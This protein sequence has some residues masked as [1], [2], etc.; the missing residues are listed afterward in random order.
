MLIIKI[1]PTETTWSLV[2]ETAKTCI[3]QNHSKPIPT[4]T[5]RSESRILYIVSLSLNGSILTPGEQ[6]KASQNDHSLTILRDCMRANPRADHRLLNETRFFKSLPPKS[7]RYALPA[8]LA[9]RFVRTGRDAL[10]HHWA[11]VKAKSIIPGITSLISI[12]LNS[13]PNAVAI[14]NGQPVDLFAGFSLLDGLPG[15]HSCG[16]IDPSLCLTLSEKGEPPETIEQLLTTQSGLSSLSPEL[17]NFSQVFEQPECLASKFLAH[18]LKKTMGGM[19]SALNALEAI[20]FTGEITP[21]LTTW[22]V[23]LLEPLAGFGFI[24]ASSGASEASQSILWLSSPA[25]HIHVILLQDTL[26]KIDYEM[27]S[28]AL[29]IQSRLESDVLENSTAS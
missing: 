1:R 15:F 14:Q 11:W 22:L 4:E 25:S 2:D 7:L 18:Q 3:I 20:V 8:N 19:A 12:Q 5:I 13:A 26:W 24:P 29:P 23:N 28:Q 17:T 9:D 10:T 6:L 27:F 21:A 16:E